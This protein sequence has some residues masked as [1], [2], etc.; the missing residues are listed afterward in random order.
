MIWRSIALRASLQ[1]SCAALA[2]LSALQNSARDPLRTFTMASTAN[3]YASAEVPYASSRSS[4]SRHFIC[5]YPCH[6]SGHARIRRSRTLQW[7][8][9][10]SRNWLCSCSCPYPVFG[11]DAFRHVCC[12]LRPSIHGLS[13]KDVCG[14]L[15]CTARL[16]D[17]CRDR[18]ICRDKENPN[19]LTFTIDRDNHITALS[20]TPQAQVKPNAPR[21]SGVKDLVR[22]A[23]RWPGPRL[24][25]IWNRLP[26]PKPVKKFTNRG[27]RY[28]GL[29]RRRRR[30]VPS[31]RGES[32]SPL[33]GRDRTCAYGK[34]IKA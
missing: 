8:A 34:G 28:S 2:I 17:S 25:E 16:R 21:F 14:Q 5:V 24:V 23:K 10:V 15:A 29:R 27:A 31:F 4:A 22:L 9:G 26:G 12:L 18:G 33:P 20:S 7:P 19:V 13:Y 6:N 1:S 11:T 32:P 30:I 3:P